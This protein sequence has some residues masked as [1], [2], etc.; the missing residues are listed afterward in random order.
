MIAITLATALLAASA[1]VIYRSGFT[2]LNPALIAG[3]CWLPALSLA[4][5]PVTVNLGVYA[6]LNEPPTGYAFVAISLGLLG[7]ASG[8]YLVRNTTLPSLFQGYT[9]P[10]ASADWVISIAYAIGLSV[11]LYAYWQSGLIQA[12]CGTPTDIAASQQQFHIRHLSLLVLL[13]D[14]AAIAVAAR[15]LMT[16][17][18]WLIIPATLPIILYLLTFQKS[19]VL[20]L[21]LC[22]I[23]VALVFRK[24]ARAMFLSTAG[25]ALM[26]VVV[27][28]ALAGAMYATNLVRGVGVLDPNSAS[29]ICQARPSEVVVP[30]APAASAP[31]SQPSI[32]SID[33]RF[34]EQ[35]FIYLGAPAIRNFAATIDGVV[36]SDAPSLGRIAVRTLLWP[37]V[38]RETLNPTRHLGGINNGTAL[39]FYWHD[40]GAVGIAALSVLAGAL[41]M[42]A[43]RLAQSRSL[44]GI[45][46]GA[47]AFNACVMSVF[48]D[49]FFEPLTAVQ[50]SLAAL[51]HCASYLQWRFR[52]RSAPAT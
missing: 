2:I 1:L 46:A 13:L 22:L 26:L 18:T 4:M 14:L 40:F 7:V 6:H 32:T 5:I 39:I 45:L 28:V 35:A 48:T 51:L 37:F 10:L 19:R 15:M 50:L 23:F 21:V 41:A 44:F 29:T 8:A 38:D 16:G 49:M 33:S 47:I 31:S 27:G 11:F 3:I 42:V 30:T 34:L 43:F 36:P 17:K 25:R 24:E 52:T 12:L 9:P 20:F